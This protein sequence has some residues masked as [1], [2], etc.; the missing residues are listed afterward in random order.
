MARI[1]HV[2]ALFGQRT[3]VTDGATGWLLSS[4]WR[5]VPRTC[6]VPRPVSATRRAGRGVRGRNGERV[7]ALMSETRLASAHG[8][9]LNVG[10][11]DLLHHS[12]DGFRT[13]AAKLRLT[14]L[15][16]LFVR[17]W[18]VVWGFSLLIGLMNIP[19]PLLIFV[20]GFAIVLAGFWAIWQTV[21]FWLWYGLWGAHSQ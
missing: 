13:A 14:N 21:T 11:H 19:M 10:R 12:V 6:T 2:N 4:S 7:P 16:G 17:F 3:A 18:M 5:L 8:L 1:S 20:I 15:L 9:L